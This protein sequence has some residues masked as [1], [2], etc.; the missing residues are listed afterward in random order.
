[1][2][3]YIN[4]YTFLIGLSKAAY[5]ALFNLYLRSLSYS[6]QVVGNATFYYSWGVA[7]GGLVFSG[8]SDRIGRKTTLILTMPI[9]SLF[10]LLR[11]TPMP[12]FW[13]Y[14]FSFLFGFFDTSVVLPTISVIESSDEKKRLKNSNINFAIVMLTGVLGYFGA[15]VLSEKIGLLNSLRISMILAL[16]SVLP[17]FKLP[18]VRLRLKKTIPTM[19]IVQFTIF[20]YYLISGAL[21]SA[22]AGVFINFGNVI[23][24]DLFAFSTSMITLILTISQ[25]ST[26]VTSLFSHKLIKK[27][28]YKFSLFFFYASVTILIFIMPAII[29]QPVSFTLAYILRYI[30]LNITTPMFT[31]FCLS[32]LPN[33]YLATFSGISYFINN[34]MRAISAQIFSYLSKSGATNYSKLFFTTGIFY[35]LNTLLTLIT[36]FVIAML[37]E[38]KVS[39]EISLFSLK[40]RSKG[41]T[42]RLIISKRNK[43]SSKLSVHLHN[44]AR[45]QKI[46]WKK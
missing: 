43:T 2:L 9:F 22:A 38:K 14:L 39:S 21:V 19:N 7:I 18:K 31:V 8:L 37:I 32:Y 4:L 23:F 34:V 17:L 46:D 45:S 30:L 16:I 5:I 24:L 28:G 40:N 44:H 42:N 35:L 3:L 26:A 1:M 6:N 33:S 36:F 29:S 10:G 41:N 25:L 13:F 27:M 12:A 11:L 20:I 15:G